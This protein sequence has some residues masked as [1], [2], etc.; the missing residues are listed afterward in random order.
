MKGWINITKQYPGSTPHGIIYSNPDGLATDWWFYSRLSGQF[1]HG[2]DQ[3]RDWFPK[4]EN[5]C[6]KCGEEIP[7][8]VK[9]AMLMGV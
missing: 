2:C 5:K 9:L 3:A 8:A 7:P 1:T 6:P 4:A